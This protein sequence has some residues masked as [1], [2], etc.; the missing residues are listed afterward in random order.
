M[1]GIFPLNPQVVSQLSKPTA[2]SRSESR[3]NTTWYLKTFLTPSMT[4]GNK[5][6]SLLNSTPFLKPIS[7]RAIAAAASDQ[8]YPSFKEHMT[9][10]QA[11]RY[12]VMAWNQI[13]TGIKERDGKHH[14]AKVKNTNSYR[15]SVCNL[16][17]PQTSSKLR[18]PSKSQAPSVPQRFSLWVRFQRTPIHLTRLGTK[19]D[20]DNESFLSILR[21]SSD[22]EYRPC[23]GTWPRRAVGSPVI[24]WVLLCWSVVCPCAQG[25]SEVCL[26]SFIYISLH[27]ARRAM[28]AACRCPLGQQRAF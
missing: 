9:V 23:M 4:F 22:E 21:S 27:G 14:A 3:A 12:G 1:S 28:A 2:K 16:P 25:R 11:Q 6:S 7:Y 15:L 5:F 18:T 10:L 17:K 26:L 19:K 13:L 24:V 8:K 20:S